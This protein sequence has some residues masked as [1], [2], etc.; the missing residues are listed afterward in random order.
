[1]TLRNAKN[2][3]DEKIASFSFDIDIVL[4]ENFIDWPIYMFFVLA[5][6]A[7]I[8]ICIASGLIAVFWVSL[9][10]VVITPLGKLFGYIAKTKFGRLLVFIF[11]NAKRV[12]G[13]LVIWAIYSLIT[14]IVVAIIYFEWFAPHPNPI[15][16]VPLSAVLGAPVFA[17]FE[18]WRIQKP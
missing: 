1:M 2:W 7:F 16:L 17:Y 11:Y 4:N 10:A 12:F 14:G 6:A 15:W 18:R 3:L 8:A 13:L 5:A 9:D